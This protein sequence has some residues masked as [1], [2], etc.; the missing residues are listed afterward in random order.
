[1]FRFFLSGRYV[2][3]ATAARTETS[4]SGG[5]ATPAQ[6]GIRSMQETLGGLAT[7]ALATS[8]RSQGSNSTGGGAVLAWREQDVEQG[9][10]KVTSQAASCV[11]GSVLDQFDLCQSGGHTSSSSGCSP[12]QFDSCNSGFEGGGLC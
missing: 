6:I 11:S 9:V 7:A 5:L 8:G 3:L 1:M 4:K 2:A 12:D 10:P